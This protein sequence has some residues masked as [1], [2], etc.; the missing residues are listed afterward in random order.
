MTTPCWYG[1]SRAP[2]NTETNT[3]MHSITTEDLRALATTNPDLVRKLESAQNRVENIEHKIWLA[4]REIADLRKDLSNANR[5][6]KRA[7]S[8]MVAIIMQGKAD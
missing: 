8:A 1:I 2:T 3:N 7:W 5:S 4:E 6:E